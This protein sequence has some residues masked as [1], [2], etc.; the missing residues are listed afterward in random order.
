MNKKNVVKPSFL[1]S[2]GMN[3]TDEQSGEIVSTLF[4][5]VALLVFE[6]NLA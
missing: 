2:W 3:F 1:V 4:N 5:L 6:K